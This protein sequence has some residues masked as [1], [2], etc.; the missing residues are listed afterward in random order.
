M[1]HRRAK[2]NL[3]SPGATP[4][5]P[6]SP[7]GEDVL[8]VATPKPASASMV[9]IP[10]APEAGPSAPADGGSG[11]DARAGKRKA[12]ARTATDGERDGSKRVRTGN[13]ARAIAQ[14]HAPPAARLADLGGVQDAVEKLLEL[15]ALPLAHPEVYMHTG[16][17]PP[18]GVLLHGPPGCG[19]TALAH[20]IA[21]VR[22]VLSIG[23]A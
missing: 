15:V 3:N 23:G 1:A 7:P 17:A 12:R 22:C 19:K 13:G 4:P 10:D 20:A 18:R 9:P 5:V 14:E 21:G 6:A 16:V 11:P 2:L 8:P